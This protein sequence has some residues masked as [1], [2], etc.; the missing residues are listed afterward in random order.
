VADATTTKHVLTLDAGQYDRALVGITNRVKTADAGTAALTVRQ[1]ALTKA[2]T[3]ASVAGGLILGALGKIAQGFKSVA[4][5][6]LSAEDWIGRV[7]DALRD[8][9]AAGANII[10]ILDIQRSRMQLVN[11]DFALTEKQM[12]AVTKAAIVLAR[13][14]GGNATESLQL[15]TNAIVTGG[16]E[17]VIRKLGITIESTA[18]KSAKGKVAVDAIVK[19]FGDMTIV[20]ANSNE[21]IAQ[22]KS[23]LTDAI[24][25]LGIA[26]TKTQTYQTIITSVGDAFRLLGDLVSHFTSNAEH[27]TAKAEQRMVSFLATLHMVGDS[28]AKVLRVFSVGR[29]DEPATSRITA[30]WYR[31]ARNRLEQAQGADLAKVLPFGEKWA[32]AGKTGKFGATSRKNEIEARL[33]AQWEAER[34]DAKIA[35][36][37]LRPQMERDLAQF[38]AEQREKER[39]RQEKI[40]GPVR[41]ELEK[42]RRREDARIKAIHQK[43]RTVDALQDPEV[44]RLQA[45]IPLYGQSGM[46][47]VELARIE[48]ERWSQMKDLGMS[49]LTGMTG[50]MLDAADAAI[51]SGASFGAAMQMMLKSTLMTIGKESVVQALKELALGWSAVGS[52]NPVGATAHFTSAAIWGGVGLAASVAGIAI[53]RASTSGASAGAGASGGPV[54]APSARDTRSDRERKEQPV[55]V[56]VR[57]DRDDPSS[58]R[59]AN[60]KISAQIKRAA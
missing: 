32:Q 44:R 45:L 40:R 22:M 23:A 56:Q 8:Q 19:R 4:A 11:G 1:D 2:M 18:N 20:A 51:N 53:P 29:G 6:A 37:K 47:Q 54:A 36:E 55:I 24:A 30:D 5:N 28:V 42:Q 43:D 50:A 3:A 41:D 7:T 59:L 15:L 17:R 38:Q 31:S 48:R 14:T 49:S 46:A 39:Q 26:I 35:I 33:A 27:G 25:E 16:T 13:A 57:Y 34:D 60:R 12:Q 58:V 21:K 9:A 10:N 52:L